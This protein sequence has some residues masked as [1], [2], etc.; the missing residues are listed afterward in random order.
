MGENKETTK[1]KETKE[2]K[3]E[4]AIEE[5]LSYAPQEPEELPPFKKVLVKPPE[6]P[7]DIPPFKKKKPARSSNESEG[8][9]TKGNENE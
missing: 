9:Q 4:K 7:K 8:Q 1:K 5:A 3:I 2:K 6:E